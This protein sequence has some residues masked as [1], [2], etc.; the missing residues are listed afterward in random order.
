MPDL[1]PGEALRI[2][3]GIIRWKGEDDADY[4]DLGEFSNFSVSSELT[5]L[6]YKSNKLGTKSV[7]KSIVSEKKATMEITL[8]SV[9]A[10]NLA[11]ALGGTIEEIATGHNRFGYLKNNAQRGVIQLEG[12]NDEGDQID[13]TGIVDMAPTGTYSPISEEWN[14]LP[15]SGEILADDDGNFGF[16]DHRAEDGPTFDPPEMDATS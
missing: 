2:G 10:T 9:T 16:W 8:N 11:L 4:R 5:K 12:T 6:E 13:F 3:A 14:E 15:M 7:V 1:A